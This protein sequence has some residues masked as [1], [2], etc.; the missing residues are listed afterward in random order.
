MKLLKARA[1]DLG[2]NLGLRHLE[3]FDVYYRELAVWNQRLNLTAITGYEDVQIKHF[4]DSLSCLL[5][6][7][8]GGPT[9]IPSTVPV[10]RTSQPLW[11]LDVGSGAGLPGLPIKI[12]LP[13]IRMTLV[14]TTGKKVTFLRHIVKTL[15]LEGVQVLNARAEDV[16][17]LPEHRERYDVV[18]ARAVAHLSVLSEYCLPFARVGGRVVA[19]KGP[20]APDEAKTARIAIEML[21]GSLVEVKPVTLPGLDSKR[22]LIV[23]DKVAK[24]PDAYPRRAG[25]PSK[26]PLGRYAGR[27]TDAGEQED[28]DRLP[29]VPGH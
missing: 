23:V 15:E 27:S 16:G 12:M 17:R 29:G 4:L 10:Q 28:D 6:L 14:E 20:D 19:P 13:D 18:L 26:R 2:L 7:T 9:A 5:A 1:A 21:G 3:L 25:I 24:T 22:H 11:F 8:P